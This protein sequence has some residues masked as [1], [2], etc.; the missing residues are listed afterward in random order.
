M[1]VVYRA[2]DPDLG[3]TVALKA[4]QLLFAIPANER[5]QFEARFVAE[6]R[7][8][9]A[10]SH[11]GIVVVHDVGRDPESGALYIALEH[12]EGKTLAELTMGGARVDPREALRLTA[13]LAEA[14]HHAHQRGVVHRDV[15]PANIMILPSGQPKIMDFGIA[16]VP[17]SELTATGQFFGTPAYMSPEQLSGEAADGR[18][19][20]FAL[21]AVLYRMLTGQDAFS[22]PNVPTVL[23]RVARHVPA[24]PS[25]IVD[26]VP[27]G[28]DE[29][30]ARALAKDPRSRYPDGV[31]LAADIDRLLARDA[32]RADEAPASSAAPAD[33]SAAPARWS[34]PRRIML[35]VS[36]A[37]LLALAAAWALVSGGGLPIPLFAPPPA[38]LTVTLEHPLRTG[39]L[40][41]FIDDALVAEQPLESTVVDDLVVFQTRKGRAA[42]AVEVP[43]GEHVVR[44]EVASGSFSDSRRIR[45]T[46]ESGAPR[47]LQA[48]VGGLVGK[49][50]S[51]WWAQ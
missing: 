22:G 42:V 30:V 47:R 1:G 20:L 41:V 14:L 26:E 7:A 11:P 45:G 4:V 27:R 39:V 3:R 21:G 38:Q 6:G 24:P 25:T 51:A 12:L 23:A 44:I 2:L 48:K 16:K 17:A 8:A 15:K 9:A 31:A 43:P 18:S 29:V 10:L 40:R 33:R 19:D 34:R 36:A 50:L 5:P 13:R 37:A 32:P 46:F 49:E 28:V 35:G